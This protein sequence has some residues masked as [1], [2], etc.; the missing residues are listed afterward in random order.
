MLH[1]GF[2]E[3]WGYFWLQCAGFSWWL[4]LSWSTGFRG[5]GGFSSRSQ[6][7]LECRAVVVVP[8]LSCSVACGISLDHV[9]FL[10][11]SSNTVSRYPHVHTC[12]PSMC[13]YIKRERE[14][15]WSISYLNVLKFNCYIFIWPG[16]HTFTRLTMQSFQS[17]N[18]EK[19]PS[20]AL[21]SPLFP[22]TT[23]GNEFK[24]YL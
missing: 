17:D 20:P 4:P 24:A 8:A 6:R 10:M 9:V 23:P 2:L 13:I 1:A 21:S 19:S 16:S 15:S 3:L 14:S 22:P 7:A 5:H 12:I 18:T 11:Y